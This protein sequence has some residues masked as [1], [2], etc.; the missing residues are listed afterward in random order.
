MIEEY[1][2]AHPIDK[3]VFGYKIGEAI[4]YG[5]FNM[6]LPYQW[7]PRGDGLYGETPKNP[8][9]IYACLDVTG[10][11]DCVTVKTT[12]RGLLLDTYDLVKNTADGKLDEDAQKIFKDFRDSLNKEVE[13]IDKLLGKNT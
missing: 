11:G 6:Y 4:K 2:L 8:L 10:G 1:S 13:W 5:S 7:A 3:E 12:M 9:T